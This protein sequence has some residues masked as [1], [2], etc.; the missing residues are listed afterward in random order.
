MRAALLHSAL[1][2]VALSLHTPAL[3]QEE[4]TSPLPSHLPLGQEACYGRAYDAD[5]MRRHPKQR[6]ASILLFRDF[7][8]D[9]ATEETPRTAQELREI[10]GEGGTVPITALVQLR[11]GEGRVL[12]NTLYCRKDKA[13]VRCGVE[14]D[15]GSIVLKPE[16]NGLLVQNNGF[17]VVGGCGDDADKPVF[18]NPDPDRPRLPP[19][20]EAG[21]SLRRGA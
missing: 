4:K 13:G 11:G 21:R 5:E 16:K 7:S 10:D 9:P 14:C 3:A 17:V 18:L 2:A 19:G 12:S 6:V 20:E 15:G 8:P 1:L